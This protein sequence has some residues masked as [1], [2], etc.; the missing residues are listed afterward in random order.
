MIVYNPL[1]PGK[2]WF[3]GRFKI[4]AAISNDGMKWKDIALLED[5]T[6][7][8]YSYPAV[9]QTQDC[10]IHITYT[11]DRKNI[12]MLYWKKIYKK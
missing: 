7:E 8:E 5:G 1:V 6:K 2:K 9:I 4:S 3:N 12:S 11:F 10:K